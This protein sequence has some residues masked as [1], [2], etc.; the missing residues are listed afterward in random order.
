[1]PRIVGGNPRDPDVEG[2]AGSS[3]HSASNKAPGAQGRKRREPLFCVVAEE[4]RGRLYSGADI[5]RFILDDGHTARSNRMSGHQVDRKE[6][7]SAFLLDNHSLTQPLESIATNK[8]TPNLVGVN[9]VINERPENPARVEREHDWPVAV[10]SHGR[11]AEQSPPVDSEPQVR[12][13][14]FSSCNRII[15]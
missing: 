15:V 1:L 4:Q 14:K 6:C 5:I 8:S 7:H 2:R 12:L 9:R 13:W 10:P 3:C 11:V